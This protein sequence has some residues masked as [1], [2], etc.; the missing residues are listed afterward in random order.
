MADAFWTT[1]RRGLFSF[2]M[3]LGLARTSGAAKK[4]G[5]KK[6]CKRGTKRCG[7]KCFNLQTS[8]TN[9]GRCNRRCQGELTCDDGACDC[10]AQICYVS[11]LETEPFVYDLVQLPDGNLAT[12]TFDDQVVIFSPTGRIVRTIGEFGTE[13]GEFRSPSGIATDSDGSLY[14]ADRDNFRIQKITPSDDITVWSF[15]TT[16]DSVAVSAEGVVYA[17]LNDEVTRLAANGEIAYSWGP[18]GSSDSFFECL[19]D[20]AIDPE[21]FVYAVDSCENS[22]IKFFDGGEDAVAVVWAV[23]GTGVDP[24]EFQNPTSVSADGTRVCVAEEGNER[25]QCFASDTAVPELVRGIEETF[26]EAV[27]LGANGQLYVATADILTFELG[28]P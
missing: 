19:E 7:K 24:G 14:V 11:I 13:A 16:P 25:I 4:E 23:V 10:T 17:D 3:A 27:A 5:K 6:R 12:L 2:G 1:T 18:D 9:C 8:K 22:L 21:G 15:S 26:T 20:V 28:E